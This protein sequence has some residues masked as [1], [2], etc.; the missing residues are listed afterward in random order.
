MLSCRASGNFTLVQLAQWGIFAL[1]AAAFWLTANLVKDEAW[2]RRLT[3]AFLLLAGG[4]AILRACCP[5][6]GDLVGRFTTIAFIRAPFWVL[7]VGLAGGQLLFNRELSQSG[8][9]FL[10]VC[11]SG[12]DPGLRLCPA[13]GGRLQLGR[14]RRGLGRAGLAA[15]SRACA[16]P[17]WRWSWSWRLAGLLFPAVYDF[18]GGDQEWTG[19][20]GSRLVLIQ[21]VID[22]TMRNPITGLGPAAYRRYAAMSRCAIERGLLGR[23]DGQLPQQLRGHLLAVGLVGLALFVWFVAEIARLG[24][25]LHHRYHGGFAA[26]YVN[27]MLAAGVGVAGDHALRRLDP[28]LRLQHRLSRLPGQRAGLALPGRA[29]GAGEHGRG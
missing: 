28:A 29:G 20:G 4:G 14:H 16:G 23:A 25:R 15:L 12:G 13:A 26:G 9:A 7:L 1:S 19:S 2:L 5:A 11:C 21:R 3:W 18:A 6:I 24:L 27:G 10:A 17:C 22:V 8:R